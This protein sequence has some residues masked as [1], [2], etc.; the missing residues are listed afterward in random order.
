MSP[1]QSRPSVPLIQG[2]V[3]S[4]MKKFQIATLLLDPN[5]SRKGCYGVPKAVRLSQRRM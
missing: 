4:A 2:L 3:V 5:D 1:Q